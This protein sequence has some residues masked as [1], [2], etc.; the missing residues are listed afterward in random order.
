MQVCFRGLFAIASV[1]SSSSSPVSLRGANRFE[2]ANADATRESLKSG[3]AGTSKNAEIRRNLSS[4]PS[5]SRALEAN[6]S[7]LDSP[8]SA[9]PEIIRDAKD[10][11]DKAFNVSND[12][13]VNAVLFQKY[14]GSKATKDAAIKQMVKR[15]LAYV[16]DRLNR[17]SLFAPKASDCGGDEQDVEAYSEED[18]CSEFNNTGAFRLNVCPLFF[19]APAGHRL[20]TIIHEA[21]HFPPYVTADYTYFDDCSIQLAISS[22]NLA[23]WNA[24]NYAYYVLEVN[25]VNASATATPKVRRLQGRLFDWR[26]ASSAKR[27]CWDGQIQQGPPNG[28]SI[29][30]GCG[31]DFYPTGFSVDPVSGR[32][33]D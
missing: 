20:L 19:D 31:C 5:S 26:D 10:L 14:F 29:S 3:E 6:T 28:T 22:P 15:T 21:T 7:L 18:P 30:L 23:V 33:N 11:V 24:D 13:P 1:G 4:S 9:L 32:C 27:L 2:Q 25:G 17:I 12:E 8:V 16:S